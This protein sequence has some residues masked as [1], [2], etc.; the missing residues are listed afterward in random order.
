MA[1]RKLASDPSSSCTRVNIPIELQFLPFPAANDAIV[2]F[3]RLHVQISAKAAPA[4]LFLPPCE[5]GLVAAAN[6]ELVLAVRALGTNGGN[7]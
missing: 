3:V 5:L 7:F 6:D 4:Y 1:E 2:N